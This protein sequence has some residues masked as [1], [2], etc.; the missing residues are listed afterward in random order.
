MFHGKLRLS[1]VFS[2]SF[3]FFSSQDASEPL[4]VLLLFPNVRFQQQSQVN[5]FPNVSKQNYK[6]KCAAQDLDIL[7]KEWLRKLLIINESPQST[8]LQHHVYICCVV[9]NPL[10]RI[11]TCTLFPSIFYKEWKGKRETEKPM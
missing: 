3:S 11:N 5:H 1:T 7:L 9:A 6:L 4:Q 10:P 2:I 8:L